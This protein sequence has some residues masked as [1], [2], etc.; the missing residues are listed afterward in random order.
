M[1][2]FAPCTS[3]LTISSP[4]NPLLFKARDEVLRQHFSHFIAKCFTTIDPSTTYL[5]NWHIDAVAEYL[6]ATRK[7][8]ITRLLINMPP[9]ALKSV[10]VSVAWPAWLL[11]HDPS[12]RIMAA[13]YSQQLALRHALDTRLILGTPWFSRLFPQLTLAQGQ[14]EKHKFVTTQRGFRFATSVGGTA[15]GEGGDV[16]IVDDPL[17]P[18]QAASS[19]ERHHANQWF[20]QT[21]ATRLN[22]KSK[23]RIVVVMQRLHSED[24]SAHLLE[25]GGWEHL[26][27]P[28][29]AH[30]KTTL[31]IG[32]KTFIREAGDVLHP[33]RENNALLQRA[34]RELGSFAFAAQ[35]QQAPILCDGGMIE[36]SWLHYSSTM[37]P[38][39]AFERITQSWDTAIKAMAHHDASACTTLGEYEG[40]HYVLDVTHLRAEYPQLK[41]TICDHAAQWQPHAILIEDKASGQSLLQDLRRESS[42]P[43]IARQPRGDKVTRVAAISPLIE[44]GLLIL[45]H[46]AP[47]LSDFLQELLNFPHAAHDDQVDA[48]SQ[49]LHWIRERSSSPARLRRI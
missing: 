24:L 21:F 13:S 17:N 33:A 6:E 32:K 15:T 48:L 42:L 3:P 29:V 5:S 1:T 40:R 26:C 41:R 12:I 25:K 20:D 10:C 22:D 9:R 37:P 11:G 35:Y 2:S 45:P 8:D 39:A 16:L 27:L 14:N 34:Q 30:T 7:S 4:S 38:L 31:T 47:W 28:A 46:N 23:G 19:I 44:S 18:A 36:A 49:Y 43:V